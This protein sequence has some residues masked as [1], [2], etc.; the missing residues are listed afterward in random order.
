MI[1]GHLAYS[2]D[3]DGVYRGADGGGYR[4]ASERLQIGKEKWDGCEDRPTSGL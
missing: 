1:R 3:S 4:G 2:G